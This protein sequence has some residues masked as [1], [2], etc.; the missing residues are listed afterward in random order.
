MNE[1]LQG[2]LVEILASIQ[3]AARATGDFAM[4]ELPDVA[5]SYVMY[6]RVSATLMVLGWAL[7][8]GA[9][10]YAVKR[11][12]PWAKEE[13]AEPVLALPAIAGCFGAFMCLSYAQNALLVWLAPKVWL[14]KEIA[15]L[16]K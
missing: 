3:N 15:S 5:Q 10:I 1:Q 13:G 8:A 11:L 4:R 16:I 14:L 7:F 9:A 12:I 6:G 2:E